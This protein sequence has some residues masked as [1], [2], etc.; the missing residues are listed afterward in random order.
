MISI[1]EQSGTIVLETSAEMVGADI[2]IRICGGEKPHLG[3]VVLAQPRASDTG[4]GT[5]SATSSVLN[6]I[7]HKD[8]QVCRKVAEYV[9]AGLGRTVVCTGGVHIDHISPQ[10]IRDT[11]DAAEKTGRALVSQISSEAPDTDRLRQ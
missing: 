10:Q 8:E 7:G 3:C 1:R 11:L 2:L 5:V 6:R 4:D 9:A